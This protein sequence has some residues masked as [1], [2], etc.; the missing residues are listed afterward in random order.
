MI[1]LLVLHIPALILVGVANGFPTVTAALLT[2]P[3][4]AAAA[5]AGMDRLDRRLRTLGATAGLLTG[6]AV[7]I[8][9]THGL[10]ESHFHFFIVIGVVL[11][12][13][14]WTVFLVAFAYV[15]AHHGVVGSLD[16]QTVWNHP[17]AWD[18]PLLW[19]G[20]HG[21]YVAAASIAH[22]LGWRLNEEERARADD[23]AGE[24]TLYA[25]ELERSNEELRA[26][27]ALK[28]DFLSR[29]SHELRTPLTT[30]AGFSET[31]LSRWDGLPDQARLLQIQ[32]I[33]RQTARL[34]RL[35]SDVLDVTRIEAGAITPQARTV[36]VRA[37]LLEA[38]DAVG[39]GGHQVGVRCP[40]ELR[41]H[42]DPDHLEQI[43]VNLVTNALKYG[44]PPVVAGAIG[45]D[46]CV[47]LYVDD[48][49]DGVPERFVGDL[50]QRFS[51]ASTGDTRTARGVGL[52]LSIVRALVEAN[53]GSVGYRRSPSGGAR[54][55]VTLPVRGSLSG[56]TEEGAVRTGTR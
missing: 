22:L 14:D 9:L 15:I 30:I 28:N 25:G 52:G 46:R 49:G 27:D 36:V 42:V 35:V 31:L 56:A 34:E 51:Q 19:A 16:P 45:G 23:Y 55:L 21:G 53:G 40:P 39:V 10:I 48:A 12:Y 2:V 5:I 32:A 29:V 47:E 38:V 24:L 18:R 44:H 41:A 26:A 3:I 20:I 11:L 33:S 8:H 37:S 6:S 4:A 17:S 50:F 7:L 13:H 1:R 54:F 43:V